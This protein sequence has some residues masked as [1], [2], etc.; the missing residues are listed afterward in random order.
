MTDRVKELEHDGYHFEAADG[1]FELLLRRETGD[2]QR[3]V[4]ARVVA[5]DRRASAAREPVE[6]DAT[7]KVRVHG[8]RRAVHH[9]EGNGPV[10]ALDQALR[11]A[12]S[13][14]HP[15][16]ERDPARRL[17]GAHRRRSQ[18]HRRRSPAC[19][20][21][22]SDGARRVGLD[23]RL[24]EHHRGLVGGARRLAGV[25]RIAAGA[26]SRSRAERA[27]P[28]AQRTARQRDHIPLAQ[29]VLG[30]REEELVLEVLRSGRLSL[31]P[32]LPEF[33][34]AFAALARAPRTPARSPAAPPA[35]TWRCGPPA[36]ARATRS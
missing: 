15:D 32:R 31:G 34:R 11:K 8:E 4:H 14:I 35:C 33:E 19:C 28:L 24:G 1:S 36:W 27:A 13:E 10:N 7:V 30:A 23:R 17:Q 9:G 5:R 25:Q 20:S 22:A 18:G 2:Y 16:L 29:P 26:R 12:I 3:A 21:T 6:C